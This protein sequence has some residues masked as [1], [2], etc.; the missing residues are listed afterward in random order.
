MSWIS[1]AIFGLIAGAIAKWIMPGKN[2]P[3]GCIVTMIL[4]IL[5]SVVGGF[6]GRMIGVVPK[7]TD[8]SWWN[9]TGFLFAV[10]GALIVLLIYGAIFGKKKP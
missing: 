4:G 10:G 6:V 8:G 3:Q 7:D 2:E 5:G 1:W 9:L